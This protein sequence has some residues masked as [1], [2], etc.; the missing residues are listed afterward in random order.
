MVVCAGPGVGMT[1]YGFLVVDAALYAIGN[2]W[3][4]L[5]YLPAAIALIL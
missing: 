1:A 5:I 3:C 2:L 4:C